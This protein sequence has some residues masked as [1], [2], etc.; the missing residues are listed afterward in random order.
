MKFARI[1]V[2]LMGFAVFA[3]AGPAMA[4]GCSGGYEKPAPTAGS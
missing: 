2:A 3:A 1:A 4:G